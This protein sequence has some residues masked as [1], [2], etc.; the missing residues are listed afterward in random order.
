[1]YSW[2][3]DEVEPH[4]R[5]DYWREVRAKGLFGVT[6]E[7]EREQRA[8]FFGEF[9]LRRVGEAGL[10]ELR[11]SPYR[12]ERSEAD[13][14]DA[15]GDSICIYQQLGGGGWFG[16]LPGD[17]FTI[18]SGR[19]AT[20]HTDLPYRTAPLGNAGFHLRILKIPAAH[21]PALARQLRGLT[22][23]TFTDGSLAPLLN[24]CFTDLVEGT[25]T[26][27]HA[28]PQVQAL[29]QLALI[30]R[31]VVNR[32][33]RRGQFALRIGRLSLARRL[34]ARH[35]ANPELS[36]A[37][38]AGMLGVSVR[39]MHM[40]FEMADRSFSHTVTEA[41]LKH[42][43]RLLVE[44]PERLIADIAFASG[45]ESLA[46]FYRAFNSAFGMAPGDFRNQGTVSA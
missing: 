7:L 36:P 24:S 17:D 37:M 38:V 5:F 29:A 30:E 45:F 32:A 25:G 9:S 26:E 27:D 43:R 44:A 16:G 23:K 34:I 39:H 33:S 2:C 3:T 41:R 10:V 40:L 12:V 28:V 18:D 42:S 22:A 11:A 1:M 21:V 15:P 6:A 13:I 35:L 31:G 14:A 46:T 20:S 8:D 4:D 19:F